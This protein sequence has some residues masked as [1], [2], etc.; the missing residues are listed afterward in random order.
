VRLL[1]FWTNTKYSV[2]AQPNRPRGKRIVRGSL[3]L[4]RRDKGR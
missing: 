4:F 1:M 3:E 2:M